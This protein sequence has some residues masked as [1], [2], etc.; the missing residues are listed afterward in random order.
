MASHK[1]E[2]VKEKLDL[3]EN[4]KEIVC[5]LVVFKFLKLEKILDIV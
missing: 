3:A 4:K 5:W 2:D 1:T